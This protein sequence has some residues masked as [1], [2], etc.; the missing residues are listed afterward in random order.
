[1]RCDTVKNKGRKVSSAISY[2]R[3]CGG[4]N[5]CTKSREHL[6]VFALIISNYSLSLSTRLTFENN[7]I[8]FTGTFVY[9]DVSR[10]DSQ[11]VILS[12]C[13]EAKVKPHT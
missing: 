9:L 7:P 1:M 12:A 10:P 5:V 8:T 2:R 11:V 6:P 4:E 13:F 3:S